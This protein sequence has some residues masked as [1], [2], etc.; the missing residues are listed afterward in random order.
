MTKSWV[1]RIIILNVVIYLLQGLLTAYQVTYTI[2]SGNNLLSGQ[3]SVMTYYFGLIPSMMINKGYVWQIASYMFL[4]GSMFH[5]F[6][7]MYALLLFGSAI[8]QTWGSKKFLFYY[9]FTGIGAGLTIFIVNIILY[10]TGYGIP[11]IGA[12]GAVFGLLLA[13]GI[14]FPEAQLLIFFIPMRAKYMVVLY[15]SIELLMLVFS[16]AD[17]SISHT[18][19]LGGLLF[20]LIFFAAE[21]RHTIKF[22]SKVNLA[23]ITKERDR[24][25]KTIEKET[26]DSQTRLS[27]ILKRLKAGGIDNLTD[28]DIQFLKFIEIMRDED[29][30]DICIQE[31]FNAEDEYCRKCENLEDCLLREIKKYR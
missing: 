8:E 13:F 24:T 9:F 29:Y 17:S 31:D 27:D 20:G 11:T 10:G 2:N 15:G 23:R 28:D 19:H 1:F 22:A 26:G 6:F 21:R 25:Q 12:S 30:K 4:H 7:N 3:M 18:G 16:G 14:L 5:I